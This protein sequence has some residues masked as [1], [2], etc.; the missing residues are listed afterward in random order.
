MLRR[1]E[2]L[3]SQVRDGSLDVAVVYSA[4]PGG[5][6][7]IED[8][9]EQ[10]LILVS[11]EPRSPNV[12]WTPGF[13]FIDWT[14]DFASQ[15]NATF[16]DSPHPRLSVSSSILA[17]NHIMQ[18]GGSAYLPQNEIRAQLTDG[19]LHRVAKAPQS[20]LRSYLVY[21]RNHPLHEVIEAATGALHELRPSLP[22][23][24]DGIA[25]GSSL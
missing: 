25:N 21:L 4:R 2:K 24:D 22:P 18:H 23:M 16:S 7:Q 5:G 14:D 8:F 17:L 12:G 3:V 20:R 19:S 1:S 6:L 13:V 9:D 15:Y 11:T 10:K